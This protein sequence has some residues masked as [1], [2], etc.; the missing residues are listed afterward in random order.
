MRWNLYLEGLYKYEN[1]VRSIMPLSIIYKRVRQQQ[2]NPSELQNNAYAFKWQILKYSNASPTTVIVYTLT[3]WK[4][5]RINVLILLLYALV[6]YLRALG[7]RFLKKRWYKVGDESST[8]QIRL[9]ERTVIPFP[10]YSIN[11]ICL[12]LFT[13]LF[14]LYTFDINGIL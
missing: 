8:Q 10:E 11:Y 5:Q 14:L 2:H 7:K 1:L 9:D 4:S 12:L 13:Q 3:S 6:Y